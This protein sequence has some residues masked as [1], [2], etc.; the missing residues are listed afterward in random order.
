M[1]KAGNISVHF[2]IKREGMK[3][4]TNQCFPVGSQMIP[5]DFKGTPKGLI[6]QENTLIAKKSAK[7]LLKRTTRSQMIATVNV[8]QCSFHW[9]KLPDQISFFH[10]SSIYVQLVVTEKGEFPIHFPLCLL[11]LSIIPEKQLWGGGDSRS[12]RNLGLEANRKPCGG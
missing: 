10:L 1:R 5:Q 6:E 2:N 9:K 8:L 7:W 3:I 12:W 11:P 4:N